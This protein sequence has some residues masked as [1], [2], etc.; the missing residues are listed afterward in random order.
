MDTNKLSLILNK[1]KELEYIHEEIEKPKK[2]EVLLKIKK[3][4]LCG[5]DLHA[6]NGKQAIFEYPRI[7]G[8]EICAYV[9]ETNENS[10]FTKGEM[11]TVMPYIPCHKCTACRN[12]KE[13]CCENLKVMGVHID[14]ASTEYFI[15]PEDHVIKTENICEDDCALIEPLS[16][17]AHAVKRVNIRKDENALV[18]GLGTIGIGVA[19]ILKHEG[20]NVFGIDVNE[21]KINESKAKIDINAILINSE[22]ITN[23]IKNHFN[24]EFPTLVFDATG[25]KFS[26]KNSI[27]YLSYGGNLVFIGFHKG[28]LG[29]EDLDL[30]KREATLYRSRA[31][32]KKDFEYI[33]D[34]IK[35]GFSP[36][37]FMI[38]NRVDFKDLKDNFE[39]IVNDENLIKCV[40]DFKEA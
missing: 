25:N 24:G 14:G 31:A 15:A 1:A 34:L 36:K 16:I 21:N 40:V 4:G 9:E 18:I 3:L 8:H 27:N 26:M 32:N 6:Y 35:N 39:N 17:G 33:I 10:K 5:S 23:D 13:N 19:A 37:D 28:E 11:V 38:T 12:G 20:I 29:I 2:G 30:H 7:I 22:T